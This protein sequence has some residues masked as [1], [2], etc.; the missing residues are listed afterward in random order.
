MKK[1]ALLAILVL[2]SVSAAVA[3]G[4]ADTAQARSQEDPPRFVFT[5]RD[6]APN[7][8]FVP[9]NADGS[10]LWAIYS[11]VRLGYVPE[12]DDATA[13]LRAARLRN[14][15]L[16]ES[17]LESVIAEWVATGVAERTQRPN[18]E[19]SS[20]LIRDQAHYDW[21]QAAWRAKVRQELDG[22]FDTVKTRLTPDRL[23]ALAVDLDVEADAY[24]D[25]PEFQADWYV[26]PDT[27]S[28]PSPRLSK[29][30]NCVPC[31]AGQ[32]PSGVCGLMCVDLDS[33]CSPYPF[34]CEMVVVIK[35]R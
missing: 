29:M 15:G 23:E 33:P 16:L 9:L 5:D 18:V 1:F 26:R 35:P 34:D 14:P 4:P 25:L 3:G 31:P 20:I 17:L 10:G 28:L 32:M 27:L 30:T 2:V 11:G 8:P 22:Y 12:R 24:G 21:L 13:V 7:D 6:W 19:G